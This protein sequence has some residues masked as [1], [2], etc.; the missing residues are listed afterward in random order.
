MSWITIYHSTS[1]SSVISRSNSIPVPYISWY[2]TIPIWILLLF[3]SQKMNKIV[4]RFRIIYRY[5]NFSTLLTAPMNRPLAGPR[6]SCITIYKGSDNKPH[7]LYPLYLHK[8][9]FCIAKSSFQS[10]K[11]LCSIFP[12]KFLCIKFWIRQN[13]IPKQ[14][15][16]TNQIDYRSVTKFVIYI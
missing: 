2:L 7:L 11:L 15:S 12:L 6:Y 13:I 5:F 14:E 9:F 1:A 3:C 8:S 10:P 4:L 16:L